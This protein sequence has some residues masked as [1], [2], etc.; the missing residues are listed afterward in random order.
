MIEA[1]ANFPRQEEQLV[2]C[3]KTKYNPTVFLLFGPE[4]SGKTTQADL[5][6]GHFQI[7]IIKFGEVFRET[8][9]ENSELGRECKEITTQGKFADFDLYQRVFRNKFEK[10]ENVNI[11]DNGLVLDGAIR[12]D[13]QISAFKEILDEFADNI[14]VKAIYYRIPG[15]LS[16]D[17]QKVRKREDAVD[18]DIIMGRINNHY[19]GLKERMD[20]IKS[21][22]DVTIINAVGKTPEKILQD[23]LSKLEVI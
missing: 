21:S 6:A 10:N 23:T 13:E 1:Q 20:K 16:F 9:L 17:R 11:Y 3:E 15:W 14:P 19:L 8:A 4:G 2:N 22:W 18:D 5:L 12:T 7:P